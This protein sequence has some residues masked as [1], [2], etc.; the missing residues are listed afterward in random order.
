MSKLISALSV[1]FLSGLAAVFAQ[2]VL[3]GRGMGLENVT[4]TEEEREG[5]LFCLL[6]GACCALS[7]CFCWLIR[8]YGLPHAG[9]LEAF[10]M[11]EYYARAYLWP[12]VIAL[13][14]SLAY[15]LVFVA[16]VKL[17]PQDLVMP[18]LNRLPWA[19]FNTFVA[20]VLLLS[21]SR[22]YSFLQMLGFSLGSSMGYYLADMYARAGARKLMK[23]EIPPAFEGLPA[24]ILYLSGLALAAYAVIGHR[25]SALI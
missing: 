9:F 21:A 5:S 18:S 17:A 15:F 24:S 19:C 20:G 6:Q 13:S 16:A 25:L 11:S 7:G 4:Q 8:N 2:N 14:V 3:L 10:G 12:L 23:R 1:F 22:N